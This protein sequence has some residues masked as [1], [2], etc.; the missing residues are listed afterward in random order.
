[1]NMDDPD[2]PPPRARF[3]IYCICHAAAIPRRVQLRTTSESSRT[4][5]SDEDAFQP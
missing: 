5:F 4:A 1:M 3:T 2:E